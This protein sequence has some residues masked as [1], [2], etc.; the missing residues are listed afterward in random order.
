M[1]VGEVRA[2]STFL[3]EN[4]EAEE[5]IKKNEGKGQD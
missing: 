1:W 2:S 3:R 5:K 4:V